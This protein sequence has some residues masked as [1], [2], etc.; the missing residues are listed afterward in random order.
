M[1]KQRKITLKRRNQTRKHHVN[2]KNICKQKR[3]GRNEVTGKYSSAG[4]RILKEGNSKSNFTLY[5]SL[6]ISGNEREF[7]RSLDKRWWPHGHTEM[8]NCS[9][10]AWVKRI[11]LQTFQEKG[12][13]IDHTSLLPSSYLTRYRYLLT[14]ESFRIIS[15]VSVLILFFTYHKQQLQLK[16]SVHGNLS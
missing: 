9:V 1:L 13:I 11:G 10:S 7:G 8:S 15:A 2:I 16:S 3:Q 5:R 4:N 12:L 6:F 14:L